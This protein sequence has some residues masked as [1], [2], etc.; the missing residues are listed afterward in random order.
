[1][2]TIPLIIPWMGEEE[3]AAVA[4]VIAS[5]WV[6]Q[7]PRVA[8]FEDAF[9]ASV[10]AS[11]GV[12]VSSA[13][14][15]LHLV[16]HAL[17]IGI[18]DEVIVPSLSFIASANS[19]R[20]TGAKPVF[21]D[22][23]RQTLAMTADL[24]EPLITERTK[25]I[26]AVHQLGIPADVDALAALAKAHGLHFIED[27]ACAAGS[28]Y[29]GSRVGGG[30][31][32]AVF[33]LHPRK[34]LTT[35]EGGMITTPNPDL[36][37]RLRRLRAHAVSASALERSRTAAST[38]ETYDELGFN[39]R[40]TDIQ[41][42]IGLVQLGRLDELITNRRKQAVVYAEAFADIDGVTFPVDPPYGETNYQSYWLLLNSNDGRRDGM[43][44]SLASAGVASK[45]IVMAAHREVV[46]RDQ[47]P[48]DLPVT[49]D[50]ADH[51]LLLPL[52]HTMTDDDQLHVIESVRKA[53]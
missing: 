19:V 26:M 8:E 18:G 40:L 30:G 25:A 2:V 52:Y 51:G 11:S 3:A 53:M 12:A 6:A 43:I 49:E 47:G 15:G 35:G 13:T 42:A 48:F 34:L 22:V 46:Y 20:H 41:A 32:T 31:Y 9:A 10:G 39:F 24:A 17:G 36:A 7:G 14:T 44:E 23:D 33:S 37:A 1:M 50:I 28:T 4:D 5:G 29:K 21:A 45:P 38:V 16:L 27:A